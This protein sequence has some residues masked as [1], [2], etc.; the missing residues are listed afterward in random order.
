MALQDAWELAQQ[1]VNAD[2]S[3][4]Q[5]T[6]SQYA[7]EGAPRSTA[8]I[9]QSRRTIAMAH[10]EGWRRLL[11]VAAL[12]IVGVLSRLKLWDPYAMMRRRRQ[13]RPVDQSMAR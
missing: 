6:I 10:C 8:A 9:E 4:L 5:P 13:G 1:L 7:V 12:R 3:S 11:L 2:H